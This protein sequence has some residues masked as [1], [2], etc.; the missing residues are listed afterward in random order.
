MCF[1]EM[2][3]RRQ[4]A[5]GLPRFLLRDA[6]LVEALQVEPKLSRGSEEMCKSQCRIARNRT[7]PVQDFGHT[8]G[9]NT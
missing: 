3:Q 4:A 9:W 1:L 5:D 2:L 8:I 7:S 6:Q